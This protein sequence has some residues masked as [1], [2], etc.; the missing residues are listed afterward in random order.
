[1]NACEIAGMS[2]RA[3]MRL[4]VEALFTHDA[5]GR[6][7]HVN[8]PGGKPAPRFFLGMTAEGCERWFRADVDDELVRDLGAACAGSH[9]LEELVSGPDGARP[10][11]QLLACRAPVE[12]VW[13]GPAYRFPERLA[14]GSI[15]VATLT[16]AS[17]HLLSPYLE[18]WIED[19]GAAL[20]AVAAIHQGRAVAICASVR[21]SAKA[22]EA[23]VETAEP[24]RRHGYA[25]A[26]VSVWANAV[27]AVGRIPLYST[28]TENVASRAL[29]DSLGLVRFGSDLHIT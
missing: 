11:V 23:G 16:E 24:F 20:P 14:G 27:R 17:S 10:L 2:D 25:A 1:M 19:I 8:E 3:L 29:A 15:S 18:P 5:S 28:S 12:R 26:A 22:H 21:I 6:L 9:D 4:H 7:L 13:T